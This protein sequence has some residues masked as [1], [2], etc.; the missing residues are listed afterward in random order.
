ME[1]R[2]ETPHYECAVCER[3]A[4]FRGK[5]AG[6]LAQLDRHRSQTGNVSLILYLTETKS[7]VSILS[8]FMCVYHKSRQSE[9]MVALYAHLT[10]KALL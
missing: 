3:G 6:C 10:L 7:I 8:G 5:P 2:T 4:P 9:G 1:G